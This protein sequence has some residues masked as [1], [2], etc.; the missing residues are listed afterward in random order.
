[1]D[2]AEQTDRIRVKFMTKAPVDH[3]RSEW[4]K[5]FPG[6]RPVWGRCEY[7]FDQEATD[8]DWVVVYDDLPA[9]AGG[10]RKHWEEVLACPRA[11][12]MLITTEPSSIKPYGQGF[13]RQ[14]GHVLTSQE[15]WCI[16]HP[17]AI[18]SQAGLIWFYGNHGE[19]ASHDYLRS[20][21]PVEKTRDIAT[22]CS[23]KQQKHTLHNDRY[24]FTQRLKADLPEM[25]VFGHGVRFIEDKSEALD[26]YRYHLAIENHI[27]EH[28]WT[29]KLSD[30]YLGM[31]LPIYYGCPNIADYFPEES[32]LEIDLFNY[33]ASLATIQK[34][35]VDDEYSQR[36]S[37]IKEARRL[38]LEDYCTFALISRLVE[39]RHDPGRIVDPEATIL[40]RHAWRNASVSNQLSF[41]WEKS[42]FRV[43]HSLFQKFK[44][45]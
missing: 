17:G 2:V 7:I 11:H 39:T 31:S 22:V 10:P 28:H 14:F 12:T 45:R 29:E 25:D 41:V 20:H 42:Y 34:A 18:F 43:R 37:A 30:C 16:R 44:H 32:Y 40:S 5:R 21:L 38:F 6:S 1:M 33:D 23:S 36:L 19:G 4:L 3:D 27:C 24:R 8:Y 15:S 9:R 13:L 35:I 26:A